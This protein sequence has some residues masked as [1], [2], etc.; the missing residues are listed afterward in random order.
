MS[1]AAP[2]G[3]AGAVAVLPNAGLGSFAAGSYWTCSPRDGG[4]Q[5]FDLWPA[6]FEPQLGAE[7][8]V[9]W[10]AALTDDEWWNTGSGDPVAVRARMEAVLAQIRSR[11]SAPVYVSVPPNMA[12]SPACKTLQPAF[13]AAVQTAVD[14][15]VA[16]G[17]VL[18]GPVLPSL[19]SAQK[20]NRCH[21]NAAGK[22]LWGQALLGAFGA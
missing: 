11:T 13:S 10:L 22:A 3:A 17:E 1:T 20:M 6:F 12:S 7:Q 18:R 15:M 9:W 14:A 5:R 4:E 8:A 21:P 16:S 2:P 19:T